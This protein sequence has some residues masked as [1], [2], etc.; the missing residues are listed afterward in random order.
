MHV[1]AEHI[2]E[3]M[4]PRRPFKRSMLRAN[5]VVHDEVRR[6]TRIPYNSRRLTRVAERL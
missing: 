6:T 4:R 5:L 3:D 1:C 2:S